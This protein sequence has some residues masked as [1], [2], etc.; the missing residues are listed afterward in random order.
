M[1]SVMKLG[2]FAAMIAATFVTLS[3]S[4]DTEILS[5]SFCGHLNGGSDQSSGSAALNLAGNDLSRNVAS[6]LAAAEQSRSNQ[7]PLKF[8][9]YKPASTLVNWDGVTAPPGGFSLQSMTDLGMFKPKIFLPDWV[10]EATPE[11]NTEAPNAAPA[12]SFF[13]P[14]FR[15]SDS[16]SYSVGTLSL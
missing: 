10:L 7:N 11:W 2:S 4:A 1:N 14:K 3:A 16:D 6:I 5:C 12:T 9:S 8:T 15:S 13:G